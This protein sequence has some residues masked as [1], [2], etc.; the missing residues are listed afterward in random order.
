MKGC[1][2]HDNLVVV[3]DHVLAGQVDEINYPVEGVAVCNACL[4]IG[5]HELKVEALN[6]VCKDCLEMG[7]GK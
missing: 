6:T 1:K 3:C 4:D 2:A 5:P 7:G